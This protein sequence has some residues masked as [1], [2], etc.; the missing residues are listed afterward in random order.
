MKTT[1]GLN[2]KKTEAREYQTGDSGI[3]FTV[4]D[5]LYE[6]R[7]KFQRIEIIRNK[8]Y[9]RVLLL[10]GLVQTTEKDEFYYH[11]MLVHPAM[12]SH[13]RPDRVLIIGGGDGG[14]LREVLKHPVEKAWLVEIDGKV[15]EACR[16]HFPWLRATFRDPRAELVVEDGNVFIDK[17]RE[18][19]DVILVDSSDPVGPSTVLHQ[20]AFYRKLKT[21]LAPGGII[22]AQAGSLMLHLESH[23]RKGAFLRKIFRH[24]ALYLGP[25][26]TYPVGMWCYDFL[27]D[28]VDPDEVKTLYLP[29][30]LKYFNPDVFR[31]SFALPNFLAE[32]LKK[33]K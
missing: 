24:A 14:A 7:S 8:D 28:R 2:A 18:K 19:F 27:S 6:G 32:R 5:V 1:K 11:E 31:G 20:E 30:G 21:K 17:V 16:E 9:G 25:V 3:F 29:D 26:P 10:D 22:A 13:P 12:A 4:K 15:I 33:G 23:A